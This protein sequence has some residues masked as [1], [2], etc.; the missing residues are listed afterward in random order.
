MQNDAFE[1]YKEELDLMAKVQERRKSSDNLISNFTPKYPMA[2][3]KDL[4]RSIGEGFLNESDIDSE[5]SWQQLF[6]VNM[7]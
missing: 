3:E 2:S 5:K 1:A 6:T 4:Y 7:P